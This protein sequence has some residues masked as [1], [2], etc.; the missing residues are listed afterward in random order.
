[1]NVRCD[2]ALLTASLALSLG[3]TCAAQD[4]GTKPPV[5]PAPTTTPATAPAAGAPA[6]PAAPG[7]PGAPGAPAGPARPAYQVLPYNENWSVLPKVKDE[8]DFVDPIKHVPL[9]EDGSIWASFGGQIRLRLEAWDGFNFGANAAGGAPFAGPNDDVFLLSRF[10]FHSDIHFGP[11]VRVFLEGKSALSTDRDLLGGR[12]TLEVDELDLQNGFV[13]VAIPFSDTG[14]KATIRAGRQELLFGKQRL[15]SPL[16]WAN[17]RRTFD[18]ISA[19]IKV[20]DWTVTPFWTKPVIVEKYEFNNLPDDDQDFMGVYAAGKIPTTDIGLDLYWLYLDKDAIAFNGVANVATGFNGTVGDE[21]RHT[22]GGRVW[23]KLPGT[24]F[25]WEIE[26]AY[27]FGELGAGDI[28]A[29]MFTAVAGYTFSEIAMQPRFFV[30]FDY[31]SGDKAAGGDV[32]TFNQL[33]PLGHAYF[34]WIDQIGRQNVIDVYPGVTFKPCKTVSVDIHGHLFWRAE[35][36]D[37]AYNAGGV[38]FR[39]PGVGLSNEIGQEID[40]LIKWQFDR[41]TEIHFGYNHLFAGKFIDQSGPSEDID[42]AYVVLQ[43][44]F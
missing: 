26:G 7:A 37:G 33:F 22:L 14:D 17:V 16:D 11:N 44:T 27:Q 5:T 13:D 34:G 9:S 18:G 23:G 29:F 35:D 20:G 4:Y 21:E 28:D 12:R 8:G 25:D 40:L 10:L 1:M 38:R 15:V 41:H 32:E 43:F 36:T 30:G 42:F 31:A 24:G 19:P 6:T 2:K 3:A 39:A